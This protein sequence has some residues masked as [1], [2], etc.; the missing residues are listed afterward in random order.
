MVLAPNDLFSWNNK[1]NKYNEYNITDTFTCIFLAMHTT[2]SVHAGILKPWRGRLPWLP[3]VFPSY[4]VFSLPLSGLNWRSLFPP[5]G[6]GPPSPKMAPPFTGSVHTPLPGS[7]TGIVLLLWLTISRVAPMGWWS[8]LC[9]T[10]KI[11][12][13]LGQGKR[14][15]HPWLVKFWCVWPGKKTG[16]KVCST[17]KFIQ[18][19]IRTHFPCHRDFSG[20]KRTAHFTGLM[21]GTLTN[22][23]S[24]VRERIIREINV[25]GRKVR[26]VSY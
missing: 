14:P 5:W 1:Y 20:L 17:D 26:E 7:G 2:Y 15:T 19:K 3:V 13:R 24:V 10:D 18:G 12:F 23:G 4:H 16:I 9:L 11:R 21:Y 22:L 8:S 25:Q 6:S